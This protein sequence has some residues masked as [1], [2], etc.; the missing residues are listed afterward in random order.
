MPVSQ[1]G[2]SALRYATV[3][4]ERHNLLRSIIAALAEHPERAQSVIQMPQ[5][6]KVCPPEVWIE[7]ISAW[8]RLDGTWCSFD[9]ARGAFKPTASQA[10]C[11][12]LAAEKW[13]ATQPTDLT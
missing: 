6:Q 10:M 9:L 7:D 1:S 4:D 13:K 5:R 11:I 8:V 2:V 3:A 12:Q